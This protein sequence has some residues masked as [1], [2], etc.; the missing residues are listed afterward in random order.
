MI[1][2]GI[3]PRALIECLLCKQCGKYATATGGGICEACTLRAQLAA[4]HKAIMPRCCPGPEAWPESADWWDVAGARL[5][6][7][8]AVLRAGKEDRWAAT[9][10]S[11]EAGFRSTDWVVEAESIIDNAP[12]EAQRDALAARVAELEEALGDLREAMERAKASV[13]DGHY[14]KGI[15]VDYARAVDKEISEAT[16]KADKALARTP[17]QSLARV[18]AAALEAAAN[19]FEAEEIES[20]D[21]PAPDNYAGGYH[22]GQYACVEWLM[23]EASRLEAEGANG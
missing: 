23:G 9:H 6:R 5:A 10:G 20:S 19:K 13:W 11:D 12:A 2:T 22:D 15:T 21:G 4:A 17:A 7:L 14:G 18:Q 8:T 1:Q 16:S 3:P